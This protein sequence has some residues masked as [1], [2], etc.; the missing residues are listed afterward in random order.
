MSVAIAQD[1]AQDQTYPIDSRGVGLHRACGSLAC[2]AK[3]TASC[4]DC[5]AR[6][7][8]SCAALSEIGGTVVPP[9]RISERLFPAGR[10]ARSYEKIAEIATERPS[11]IFFSACAHRIGLQSWVR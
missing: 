11:G 2:T 6:P 1:I 10:D 3:G 4:D 8:T 5:R 9:F 7:V